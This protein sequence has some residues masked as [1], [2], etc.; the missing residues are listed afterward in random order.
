MSG[1]CQRQRDAIFG[2]VFSMNFGA[3]GAR[4]WRRG[5]VVLCA[6]AHRCHPAWD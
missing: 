3:L 5:K 1:N 4:L 6:V 2:I